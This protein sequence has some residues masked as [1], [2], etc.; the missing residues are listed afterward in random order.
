MKYKA[1][2]PLASTQPRRARSLQSA[3][4]LPTARTGRQWSSACAGCSVVPKHADASRHNAHVTGM[5]A[6]QRILKTISSP[7]V[8]V[9]KRQAIDSRISSLTHE[10]AARQ[11]HEEFSVDSV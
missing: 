7:L 10:G 4:S 2:S 3:L 6:L 8:L 9:I 5:D 1:Q 11:A